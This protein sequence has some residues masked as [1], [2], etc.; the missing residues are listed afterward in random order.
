MAVLASSNL[1]LMDWAQRIDPD[2]EIADIVE[3]LSQKNEILADMPWKMGN[4]P[5]GHKTTARTGLPTITARQLN[6]GVTPTKSTTTQFDDT[7]AILEA[8]SNVDKRVADMNGDVAKFRLSEADSFLEAMDQTMAFYLFYADP[9]VS[10]ALFRGLTPRYNAISGAV[11]AANILS[12]GGSSSVNTSIW[13]VGWSDNTICGIF[14]KGSRAGLEHYD[15][16]EVTI[17][18]GLGVSGAVL[19]A[20]QDRFVWECGL[21]VRDWR[22]AVRICNIDTTNLVNQSSA[23]NLITLM[24]RALYRIPSLTACRPVWYM[25]R[26][27][28][29]MLDV[30]GLLPATASNISPFWAGRQQEALEQWRDGFRNV[31]IRITDALLNTEAQVV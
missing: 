4:L 29:S 25:N 5:L 18:A 8:W 3:M 20:Y 31:P 13:L 10:P 11:N 26:T 19:R 14:P 15:Y 6:S 1:T 17:Q 23:A 28:R 7:C 22:F 30:Q 9:T 24:S 27:V 12:G 21:A 16:G 2:G